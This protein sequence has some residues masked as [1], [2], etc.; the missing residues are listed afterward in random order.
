MQK[1]IAEMICAA[2]T[3]VGFALAIT[4]CSG[5]RPSY[6]DERAVSIRCGARIRA[7]A[8]GRNRAA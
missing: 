2:A 6:R 4:A 5:D 1:R 7:N 8:L 3:S